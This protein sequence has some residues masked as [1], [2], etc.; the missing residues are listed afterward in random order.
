MLVAHSLGCHLIVKSLPL[1]AEFLKGVFFVA[2][3]DL[4]AA[5]L[6]MDLSDFAAAAPEQRVPGWVV[7]SEDDPFA[8]VAFSEKF[9]RDLGF[10]GISVG[11][12]GHINAESGL[13]GWNEGHRLFTRFLQS[14]RQPEPRTMEIPQ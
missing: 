8:P 5:A 11:R 3:P 1:I 2:P 7:Y 13:G 4:A 14:L 9:A 10:R 12:L 6:G